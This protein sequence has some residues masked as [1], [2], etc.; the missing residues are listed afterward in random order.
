MDE[1]VQLVM[2]RTGLSEEKARQAVDAV[3]EFLKQK[4]PDPVYERLEAVIANEAAMDQ[5]ERLLD[6][7]AKGLGN[8]L[9][10]KG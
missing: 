4:L 10:K 1:V 2:E 6:Q 3:M 9:G 5:A 7:G 8:L